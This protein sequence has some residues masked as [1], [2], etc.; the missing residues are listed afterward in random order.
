MDGTAN[1]CAELLSL[2]FVILLVSEPTEKP[3]CDGNSEQGPKDHAN[4]H[5]TA[6]VVHILARSP[7]RLQ[8]PAALYYQLFFATGAFFGARANK[9]FTFFIDALHSARADPIQTLRGAGAGPEV[10]K[11][12]LLERV[13]LPFLGVAAHFWGT[14]RTIFAVAVGLAL[15]VW[16]AAGGS[17]KFFPITDTNPYVF[18]EYL[19]LAALIGLREEGI[20][21]AVVDATP[22]VV[23]FVVLRDV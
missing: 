2:G 19:R 15:H 7:A 5:H 14:L 11:C 4:N 8:P 10:V 21:F 6:L 23:A 18:V 3:K 17:C 20:G 1:L 22:V 12:F 13:P 16:V 9:T